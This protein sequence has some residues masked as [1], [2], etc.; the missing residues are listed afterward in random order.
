M[1][2]LAESYRVAV[3]NRRLRPHWILGGAQ[4]SGAVALSAFYLIGGYL[5]SGG[6]VS[7]G[8]LIAMAAIFGQLTTAVNQ[9]APA[10]V[11]LRDAWAR[12]RRIERELASGEPRPPAKAIAGPP[13]IVGHYRLQDV[14]VRAGDAALLRRVSLDIRPSRI[15]AI[16]GRSGAG[17]TTLIFTLLRLLDCDEGRILLDGRPLETIAREDLWRNTGFM[18]QA[19]VLFRGTIRENICVG[20]SIEDEAIDRA[21]EAAGLTS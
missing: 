12:M 19:A 9:L 16:T 15:T 21:C 17:K 14:V 13:R 20:R 1:A 4:A 18:P 8:S 6:A 11:E 3:L 10:F 5:V 2:A 7:T